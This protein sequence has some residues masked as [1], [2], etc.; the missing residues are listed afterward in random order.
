M[1]HDV[2]KY[3]APVLQAI[4]HW[5]AYKREYFH[6]HLLPE[7]AIVAELTQLL[8]A[9]IDFK[10]R[11]DCEVMYKDIDN[12]IAKSIRADITISK[13]VDGKEPQKDVVEVKRYE[14]K[15]DFNKILDDSE[16]LAILSK[17][18]NIRLFQI[19]VGQRKQPTELITSNNNAKKG[20][21]YKRG[22]DIDVRARICKKAYSCTKKDTASGV[23]AL[24]L[25]INP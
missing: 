5:V 24:L 4:T 23:Y 25:E 18:P 17:S 16:K 13:T 8:S 9:K 11:I 7:G 2:P 10:H 21:L 6:N 19:V 3:Y 15:D 20:N 22:K 1:M 12:S 14:N